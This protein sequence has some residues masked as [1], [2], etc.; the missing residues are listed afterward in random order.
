MARISTYPTDSSVSGGDMLIGTDV[1]NANATKNFTVSDL[2]SY[3][4]SSPT[5]LNNLVPYTGATQ[6]VDLGSFDLLVGGTLGVTGLSTLGAINGTSLTLSSTLSVTG[7]TTLG[8]VDVNGDVDF[9]AGVLFGGAAGT[10][11]A[12][13]VS[14]GSGNSPVWQLSSAFVPY[15]GASSSVNLGANDLSC[16][17]IS[18]STGP[19]FFNGSAGTAGNILV[20]QGVGS[21]PVWSNGALTF[22]PYTGAT[23]NVDLGIYKLSAT[24]VDTKTGPLFVNGSA[25]TLNQVLISQGAGTNPLWQTPPY[26]YA[27]YGSFYST[28]TQSPSAGD[29]EPFTYNNTDFTSGDIS[30]VNNGSGQP[31]RITFALDGIYNIQFSAQLE[32]TGGTDH[33]A[34]IWLRKGGTDIANTNTH[35]TMKANANYAVAAW[36]FF[37]QIT[38]PSQYIEIMWVQDGNITLK[39]E[40]PDVV[41]PHPATP[42]VILT[43]N[44]VSPI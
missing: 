21:N 20:S 28:Q 41:V 17:S 22:V 9:G 27:S 39:Y 36:N 13:L 14:G 42:S 15:V 3:L 19:L 1:D 5:T 12:F 2:N 24:G 40:A 44:R 38:A 8:D 25:G 33:Q 43:V 18:I 30:I 11:G 29:V 26:V 10:A 23:T 4:V 37:V 6:N 7:Q 32:K 34:S 16:Y 31:S 35:V